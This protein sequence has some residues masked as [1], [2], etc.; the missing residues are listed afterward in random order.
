MLPELTINSVRSAEVPIQLTK[1][2]R[3]DLRI[4]S[5]CEGVEPFDYLGSQW[6]P[7]WLCRF[8]SAKKNSC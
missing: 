6:C 2:V 7:R 8:K 4:I 1:A 3:R 5:L